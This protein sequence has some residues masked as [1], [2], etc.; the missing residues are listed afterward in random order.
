M[1]FRNNMENA[2]H[3]IIIIEQQQKHSR[4]LQAFNSWSLRKISDPGTA[5]N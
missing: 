5:E 1:K 2:G 3:T 4:A